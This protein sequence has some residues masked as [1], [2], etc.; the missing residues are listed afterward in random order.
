[1]N[2]TFSDRFTGR[3]KNLDLQYMRLYEYNAI[4]GEK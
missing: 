1:M 3:A 4:Y 2:E